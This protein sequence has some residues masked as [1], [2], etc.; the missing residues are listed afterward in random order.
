MRIP[1]VV[2]PDERVAD[3][4]NQAFAAT[5]VVLGFNEPI[6]WGEAIGSLSLASRSRHRRDGRS[7][8]FRTPW[9]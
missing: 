1:A 6:A 8:G 9:R 3:T 2:A 4:I 7:I 5:P